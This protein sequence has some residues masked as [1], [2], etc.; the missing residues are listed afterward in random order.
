MSL[1]YFFLLII[2][3]VTI[4]KN[5]LII[6]FTANYLFSSTI[7]V[8]DLGICNLLIMQDNKPDNIFADKVFLIQG[9]KVKE[10]KET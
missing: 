1:I 8:D 3:S 5:I 6:L 7:K 2:I 4:T 10:L 9:S